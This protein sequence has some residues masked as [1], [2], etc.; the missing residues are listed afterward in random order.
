MLLRIQPLLPPSL[1]FI[2]PHL[3]RM[4]SS[5]VHEKTSSSYHLKANTLPLTTDISHLCAERRRGWTKPNDF[6]R[7]IVSSTYGHLEETCL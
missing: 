5:T 7:S 4:F 2:E 3:T 6:E 1:L